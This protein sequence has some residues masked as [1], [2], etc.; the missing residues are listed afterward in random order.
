MTEDR[1]RGLRTAPPPR[2]RRDLIDNENI[3]AKEVYVRE[4]A[5]APTLTYT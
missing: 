3:A 2:R 5:N 4:L 1:G